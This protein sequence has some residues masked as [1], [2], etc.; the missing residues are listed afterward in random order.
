MQTG[1]RRLRLRL[2]P[3]E[4]PRAQVAVAALRT[5]LL[6]LDLGAVRVEL[7]TELPLR[8]PVSGKLRRVI[9]AASGR[10]C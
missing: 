10:A 5:Y 6:R 2:G 3:A 8:D 7:G 4:Q 1:P 9:C